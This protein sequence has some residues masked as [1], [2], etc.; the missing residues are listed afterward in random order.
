MK[1][2]LLIIFWI[3]VIFT[4]FYF[5]YKNW[6]KKDE[7]KMNIIEQSTIQDGELVVNSS[8]ETKVLN[9]SNAYVKFEVKY[10]S[11]KNASPD[12]NSQIET[13][14]K[15]QM[16]DHVKISEENWQ[17][18]YDTQGEGENIPRVPVKDEDKFSFFSDFVIVQSN[19]IYISFVLKYGGFSG[20]AHGYENIISFNYD[21]KNQKVITLK[22]LFVNNSQYLNTLSLKSREYLNKQ[23]ATVSEEDKKNSTPEAIKEYIDNIISTIEEGTMPIEENFSIFTFT[24]DKIKIYFSQYQVGPYSMGMPEVEID[25]K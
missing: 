8:Y 17:A 22:D 21:V 16:D 18:R 24:G 25:R 12:F 7:V 10:P 4:S 1:K 15:T 14:I 3:I 19:P 23:F 13:L 6:N 2:N 11:F 9:P 5:I 20:G